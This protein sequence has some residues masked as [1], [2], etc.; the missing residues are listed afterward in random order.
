MNLLQNIDTYVAVYMTSYSKS[1]IMYQ[2]HC[3]NLRFFII[4]GVFLA[5]FLSMAAVMGALSH[6][7]SASAGNL[8]F[9]LPLLFSLL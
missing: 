2:H 3:E 9:T 7:K 1:L 4:K 8:D 6:M 5:M